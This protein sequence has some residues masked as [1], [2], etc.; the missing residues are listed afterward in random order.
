MKHSTKKVVSFMVFALLWSAIFFTQ[1]NQK[2]QAYEVSGF[3]QY[4]YNDTGVRI[5]KYTGGE[6]TV[7]IPSKIAGKKVT[8]IGE[9]AFQNNDIIENVQFPNT[10]IRI[11]KG[12]F[13]DCDS[14]RIINIPNSVTTIDSYYWS[15]GETFGGCDALTK[16]TIGDSV[17][18]IG[19]EC[20][21]DCPKLS[22]VTIG[23]SVQYID[24]AAFNNCDSLTF[25]NIPKSVKEIKPFAFQDCNNLKKVALNE[26]LN[27]IGKGAFNNCS[28]LIE[29]IIPNSV[30]TIESYYWSGGE[31]FGNC[32]SLEKVVI[33]NGVT[34][35]QNECFRDNK[36]LK[37]VKLGNS[38]Q[39]IE[40]AA[41][42]GCDSLASIAI[43]A[44]VKEIGPFSFQHCGNLT[45]I[46]LSYGLN[47]IGK[48]AF[49]D[50]DSL[51][52]VIL[53]KSVERI[54]SYYWSGGET[55]GDCSNLLKVQIPNSVTSIGEELI[56][57]SNSAVIAGYAG[58]V[59]AQYATDNKFI[60]E[61]LESYPT[62]SFSFK[63]KEVSALVG[64]TIQLKYNIS[65]ID[66]T[67]AIT[68][69]SSDSNIASVNNVGEV[70]AHSTG[71]VSIIA[72]TT[73][74]LKSSITVI[75]G[76]A[77]YKLIFTNNVK[78]ISKDQSYTQ[79]AVVDDGSRTDVSVTY[80]SSD[81]SIAA[82]SAG[83]KVTPK[84][85][86]KVTI[87][88]T[89]YN[90]LSTS[91]TLTVKKAPS[92]VALKPT[93]LTLKVKEQYSLKASVAADSYSLKYTY[94]SS[95]S[96]VV[97]VDTRGN[98]TAIKKG[99]AKITVVTHNGKK[100]TCTITVK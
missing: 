84:K 1:T 74:G 99:T 85:T 19:N 18:G 61:E 5:T 65:P 46:S 77:P 94:S 57:G 66:T 50:C 91:Y 87:Y 2:A 40:E 93:R 16:V 7:N 88:A 41:F 58:S 96:S 62:V 90:G 6:L 10:I 25:I 44:S 20:F 45:T 23:K 12:A 3:Y 17:Q 34:R 95:N 72:T 70:T 37:T 98:I 48:G 78:V 56:T 60:F 55:F 38:I 83:G 30:V 67:D 28:S 89:T 86:G 39:Y 8:E 31:T 15:G 81:S 92:T 13:N 80:K 97:K 43:P 52:E 75:V 26:G 33:G 64:Q 4:E 35:I 14:I 27:F 11:G 29:I 69:K 59:A 49:N 82:V 21:R 79:K 63:N 73:S 24:E 53:P 71:S 51:I 32:N 9:F 76:A 68:W 54:E 47:V 22:E 100:A 42:L 36:A